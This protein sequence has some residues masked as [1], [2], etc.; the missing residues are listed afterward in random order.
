MK[1]SLEEIKAEVTILDRTKNILKDKA[2]D[3]NDFL[4]DLE[5]KKG[6]TGYSKV[7]DQIQDASELKEKIDNAKS[8]SMEVLTGL[9]Q[10]IDAEVK[11]KK[12]KLAP[13][14]KRLRTLRNKF[15]DI[16]V[17]YNEKKRQYD[18]VQGSLD[19][20]KERLDKDIG[21]HVGEYKESEG[22]FH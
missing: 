5:K 11:E 12:Q 7:E 9:I 22:K 15:S 6:I 4:K 14:I 1:K 21:H 20:E 13:E 10:K 16:E 2:G 18:S 3:V 19:N 8:Q 17:D